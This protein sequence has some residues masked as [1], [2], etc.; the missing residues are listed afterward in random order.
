GDETNNRYTVTFTVS[1]PAQPDLTPFTPNGWDGPIVVATAPG[2]TTDAGTLTTGDT[3][4]VDWA[5]LNQGTVSI[6]TPFQVDLLLDGNLVNS[7]SAGLPLDPRFYTHVNDYSL[8]QLPAG[9]HTLTLVADS[10]DQVAE[11]DET[12]NRFSYTFSVTAP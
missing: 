3:L 7:W 8:G 1:A 9:T 6:T 10:G 11:S 5:V 12:N 2:G 4:Y